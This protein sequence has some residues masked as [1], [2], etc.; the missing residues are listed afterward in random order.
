M[1]GDPDLNLWQ[2]NSLF[3][4]VKS[5]S[6]C[7]FDFSAVFVFEEKAKERLANKKEKAEIGF[8]KM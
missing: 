6:G 1:K 3:I 5:Q 7:K 2:P 8:K 4:T